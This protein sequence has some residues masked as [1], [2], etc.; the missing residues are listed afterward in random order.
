MLKK[1]MKFFTFP[2]LKKERRKLK[3]RQLSVQVFSHRDN[4][5][6]INPPRALRLTPGLAVSSV[7]QTITPDN[8]I[9]AHRNCT[10]DSWTAFR[11]IIK[12]HFVSEPDPVAKQT[13]AP[14]AS[15]RRDGGSPPH[16]VPGQLVKGSLCTGKTDRSTGPLDQLSSVNG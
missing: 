13:A 4:I 14:V 7:C 3:A 6:S 15:E 8:M 11:F 16:T 5:W 10:D 1:K 12:S 2:Q 9:H